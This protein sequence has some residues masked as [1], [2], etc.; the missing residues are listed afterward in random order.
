MTFKERVEAFIAAV[1]AL[2]N[3]YQIT[4]D[5]ESPGSFV[6]VDKTMVDVPGACRYATEFRGEIDVTDPR[7]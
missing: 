1:K 7:A 4:L 5:H 2:E 3:T 6:Y